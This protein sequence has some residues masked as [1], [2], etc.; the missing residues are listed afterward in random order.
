[1]HPGSDPDSA[2]I[3]GGAPQLTGRE[4]TVTLGVVLLCAVPGVGI[5]FGSDLTSIQTG[6]AGALLQW[7]TACAALLAAVGVGFYGHLTRRGEWLMLCLAL[8]GV[9]IIEGLAAGGGPAPLRHA[10]DPTRALY[11]LGIAAMLF[12]GW[13]AV[14]RP[15]PG[16]RQHRL[17]WAATVA[18]GTL[19]T[20]CGIAQFW[21]RFTTGR[22]AGIPP[23][24]LDPVYL[25]ALLPFVLAALLFWVVER[26]RRTPLTTALGLSALPHAAA[27][28]FEGCAAAGRN[29]WEFTAAAALGL[30][31]T[32]LPLAGLLLHFGGLH[33]AAEAG[34]LS[35]QRLDGVLRGSSDG[36][37]DWNI[38][39]SVVYYSPRFKALLGYRDDEFGQ[40]AADWHNVL[41]PD[42]RDR[43]LA[44]VQSHLDTRRPYE[45]EYRM[46]TRLGTYRWFR[47]H[48]QAFRDPQGRPLRMAGSITDV[49]ERRQTEA[50]LR[51]AKE[52]AEQA[53]RAK[54][55]F[56]AN[57]SH[58]LR[59]PMNAIIGFTRRLQTRLSGTISERDQDAL[60]TVER[61]A[62]HLLRLINDLLDLSKVEAGCMELHCTTFD[63]L[64]A[65]HEVVEITAPLAENKNLAIRTEFPDAPLRITADAVKL[66][67]MTMN[68]ISNAINYTETGH[69]T[70]RLARDHDPCLGEVAM[71]AV[72]DTGIGISPEDQ[73]RVFEKFGRLD[74]SGVG[75][76]GLGLP[77]TDE[78][79]R[80]HGGCLRLTSE[81]GVGS[82][83]MITL[84]LQL[85]LAAA[86]VC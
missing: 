56:L 44:A 69:I 78:Y 61:N 36:I 59:T 55:D 8:A 64:A 33:D 20:A 25:W 77:L 81:P 7:A 30:I 48:G 17:W 26:P 86:E 71:I 83:F 80:L 63:L 52:I 57:M 15:Q 14:F 84:P 41:H 1:M 70:V 72:A 19:I 11:R 32:F 67:H 76:T 4:W 58:E 60:K 46:R 49:T 68:L 16:A 53:T 24:T 45:V 9:A 79:V 62:Q 37:W 51:T 73:Q 38:P 29:P 66:K 82:E 43:V 13:C 35:A 18:G 42:D 10:I 12:S 21:S 22:P 3:D 27:V 47:S 39:T 5:G 50:E 31:A 40:Q 2:P 85:E 75:G 34:R 65:V 23:G 74:R 54:S 6:S 28:W